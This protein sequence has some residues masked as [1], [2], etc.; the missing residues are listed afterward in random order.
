M[1]VAKGS[2]LKATLDFIKARGGERALDAT[3][4]ALAPDDCTRILGTAATDEIPFALLCRLW[5][6]ADPAMT[7]TDKQWMENAGAFSIESLGSQLYGNIIRKGSP[8]EFLTQ[9]IK[10]FR[11]YYHSGDMRVVEQEPGRVILRMIDFDEP[12]A[13]FCRRQSGGLK[14]ALE[15]AGGNGA[16]VR[17]V[18][19]VTEGDAFC[20]WELTWVLKE[21]K[22]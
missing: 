20:E 12:D 17:H 1:A 6:A 2:A 14:R 16:S 21:A 19:C 13:L 3:L 15:L 7:Q 22:E 8:I 10:L 11:L 18:R 4:D 9:P 5:H